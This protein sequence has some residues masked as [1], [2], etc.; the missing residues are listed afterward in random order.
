MSTT[1]LSRLRY[2]PKLPRLAVVVAI[3]LAAQ[4]LLTPQTHSYMGKT[5]DGVAMVLCKWDTNDNTLDD[6]PTSDS[7]A[8]TFS[9]L[10]AELLGN[11]HPAIIE[12]PSARV[13]MHHPTPTA[14]ADQ[15]T[16][17]HAFIRAPPHS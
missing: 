6:T 2:D 1:V 5:L 15:P 11:A 9:A 17:H 7:P 3:V 4:A 16:R 12:L 10:A 8:L 13:V 14:R